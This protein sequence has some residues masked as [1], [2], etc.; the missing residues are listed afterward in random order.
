[1]ASNNTTSSPH[2][3][4]SMEVPLKMSA[5]PPEYA[6]RGSS[7]KKHAVLDVFLRAVLFATALAGII[8][9]VTAEQT[10]TFL[11]APGV[12]ITRTAKFSHSPAY[13]YFV[14]AMSVAA[15][16]A[17]ISGL[18]SVFALM[19]PGGNSA[20]LMFHF[21]IL[22][23]LLLGIVASTTGA[24]GGAGYIGLKGNSHS[25]WIKICNRYGSYCRHFAAGI[26]LSLISAIS[27]LLL[28]WLSV[29]VLSKKIARR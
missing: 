21:V 4:V 26:L 19:K 8:L 20:K 11:V 9:M 5:P 10:K 16:Y 6:S 15:L 25:N 22:D 12:S 17:L 14:A 28:V 18:V 7:F 13:I 23:A 29:Y 2:G 3:A 1:M 24:S 27:L